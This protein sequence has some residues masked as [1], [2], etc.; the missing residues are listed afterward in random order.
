MLSATDLSGE[1]ESE[2]EEEYE[3]DELELPEFLTS[4]ASKALREADPVPIALSLPSKD[5]LGE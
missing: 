1:A 5:S 2:V 4:T 3:E